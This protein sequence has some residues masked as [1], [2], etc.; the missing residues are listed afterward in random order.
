MPDRLIPDLYG[1]VES[2]DEDLLLSGLTV[3]ALD[4]RDYLTENPSKEAVEY[5]EAAADVFQREF[6]DFPGSSLEKPLRETNLPGGF[7]RE[8]KDGTPDLTPL[9]DRGIIHEWTLNPGR[10]LLAKFREKFKEVICG[11]DGPYQ[12]FNNGLVGQAQLPATIVA[13]VLASG[14]SMAAIGIPLAV[15]LA[16]LLIRAGLKT[17]CES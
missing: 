15:Y 16:V 17:Y 14:F 2:L 8:A 10:R 7:A 3:L 6:A 12:Q 1:S 9:N 11:K 4:L 5:E 13:A